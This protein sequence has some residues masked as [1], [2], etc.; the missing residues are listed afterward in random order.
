MAEK[1]TRI[2]LL[3]LSILIFLAVLS[4]LILTIY[5]KIKYWGTPIGEIPSWAWWIMN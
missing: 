4:F 3:I 5:V 1:I 2:I